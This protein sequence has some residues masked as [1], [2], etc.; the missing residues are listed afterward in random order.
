MVLRRSEWLRAVALV[1]RPVMS[2]ALIGFLISRL[3]ALEAGSALARANLVLVSLAGAVLLAVN[4]LFALKWL[5]LL[6]G[7]GV[8]ISTL[9]ALTIYFG[10]LFYN[11]VLPTGFGGD[12]MRAYRLGDLTQRRAEAIVRVAFDRLHSLWALAAVAAPSLFWSAESLGLSRSTGIVAVSVSLVGV[13]GMGGLFIP[14]IAGKVDAISPSLPSLLGSPLRVA[15]SPLSGLT[16]RRA[17]LAWST[18]LA[19]TAQALACAVQYL[20][21][22]ALGA[23]LAFPLV[24]SVVLLATLATLVP[25]SVNGIG[26]REGVYVLLL[27][28]AGVSESVSISLSVIS[29]ALLVAI[30][31]LGGAVLVVRGVS[32]RGVGRWTRS[33]WVSNG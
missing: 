31:L 20:L 1:G 6:R 19:L 24:A 5:V 4:L 15:L 22:R 21:V 17:L 27:T 18:I 23:D 8:T 13:F 33:E 30:G 12:A 26:L 7:Q 9:D 32:L 10:G 28:R 25:L 2:V 11:C 16:A 29:L 3:P 14:S